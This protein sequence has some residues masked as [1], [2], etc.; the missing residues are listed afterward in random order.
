MAEGPG[1]GSTSSCPLCGSATSRPAFEAAGHAFAD[2]LECRTLF[3]KDAPPSGSLIELYRE[4]TTGRGSMLCWEVETRHDLAS[5]GTVLDLASR[6]TGPGPILD[7]GCGSG[8]FLAFARARGWTDL[9]GLEPSARAAAAARAASGATIVEAA[10]DDAELPE[11]R[12]AV[13]SLWD[14]IEH[15]REPRQALDRVA[16]L[17]RPGGMVAIS[18]PNRYGV[19]ASIF[20]RRSVVVCPPEHLLLASRRGLRRSLEAAGLGVVGIWSEDIRIREWTRWLGRSRPDD[21]QRQR[22]RG[23]QRKLTGASWFEGARSVA[24]VALRATR[25]GDQLLAVARRASG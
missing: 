16:R 19:A 18:T 10:L 1:D 14:V 15:L 12:Y 22:Y 25:L 17:L 2:C 6:G 11:S 3:V 13:V 7:V 9:T 8:P 20:G 5:F 21:E 23:L 24:N 4:E